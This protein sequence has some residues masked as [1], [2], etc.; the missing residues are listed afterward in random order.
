MNIRCIC[1][2]ETIVTPGA[3]PGYFLK[4]T[5]WFDAEKKEIRCPKCKSTQLP[6]ELIGADGDTVK[7]QV[8]PGRTI[9]KKFSW[10]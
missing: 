9:T 6:L 10:S 3:N 1:G 4:D 5:S 7:V 8:V 2:N